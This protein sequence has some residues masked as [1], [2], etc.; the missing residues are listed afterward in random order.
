M[1]LPSAI[2]DYLSKR[3]EAV[4]PDKQENHPNLTWVGSLR[5]RH[6]RDL[7]GGSVDFRFDK[8]GCGNV[9]G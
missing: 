5:L 4:E 9:A 6:E 1:R 3:M 2:G 7:G 8:R